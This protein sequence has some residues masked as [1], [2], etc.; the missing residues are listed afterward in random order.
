MQEIR[1]GA[2]LYP[3]RSMPEGVVVDG[4]RQWV[5]MIALDAPS[6]AERAAVAEGAV[7]VGCMREGPV[8]LWAVG[9]G[10][11]TGSAAWA[12]VHRTAPATIGEDGGVLCALL[13]V[14]AATTEVRA[15]RVVGVPPRSASVLA[16]LEHE[17]AETWAADPAGGQAKLEGEVAFTATAG[18][19][20]V[21]GLLDGAS[22][23]VEVHARKKS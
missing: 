15:M 14:D 22:V 9:A 11:M 1:V 3:G 5:V 18:P 2:R 20:V 12:P 21:A 16:Q 10:D 13:L 8:L 4:S 23:R 6:A 17:A 7:R 19:E